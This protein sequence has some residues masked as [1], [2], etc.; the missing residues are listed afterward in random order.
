MALEAR[1][2]LTRD[3]IR[4]LVAANDN[5][6]RLRLLQDVRGQ[7]GR[8]ERVLEVTNVDNSPIVL[9]VDSETLRVTKESYA[10]GGRGQAL[11]EETF[12]DYR[13]VGGVQMPFLAVR[14]IGPL[15]ITRRVSDIRINQPIAPS[16][17]TRRAP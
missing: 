2:N 10:A 7:Q 1:S 4:L 14:S 16:L 15:R 12:S 5:G 8:P 13:A 11:V 3:V 9:N 17:F 6:L